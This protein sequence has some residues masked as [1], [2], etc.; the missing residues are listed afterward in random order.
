MYIKVN[1]TQSSYTVDLVN[2][3][4]YI[5]FTY[6]LTNLIIYIQTIWNYKKG[7]YYTSFYYK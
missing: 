3:I 4:E 5:M 7:W 1:C 2:V 6:I